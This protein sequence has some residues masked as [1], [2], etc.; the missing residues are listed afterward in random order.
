MLSVIK[1]ETCEEALKAWDDDQYLW[2]V[3]MA[4]IGPTHEQQ[5]QIMGMECL[6]F[7]LETGAEPTIENLIGVCDSTASVHNFVPSP[8]QRSYAINLASMVMRFGW[9]EAI[10]KAEP[11]RRIVVQKRFP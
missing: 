11:K 8:Q 7:L 1:P 2:S 5:I 6:R 3:Q 9:A 4:G 10:N